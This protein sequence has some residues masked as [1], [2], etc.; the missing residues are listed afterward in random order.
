MWP[1]LTGVPQKVTKPLKLVPVPLL[2]KNS[3]ETQFSNEYD[4]FDWKAIFPEE[5][6]KKN[7][8]K[9]RLRYPQISSKQWNKRSQY[10]H[11]IKYLNE[12]SL[13]SP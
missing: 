6:D 11:G 9:T 2:T 8:I 5:E 13:P 4:I 1:P 12:G 7:Y 3:I 10:F